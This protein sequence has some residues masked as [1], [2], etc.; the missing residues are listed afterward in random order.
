MNA[1]A[2]EVEYHCITH[3]FICISLLAQKY[4]ILCNHYAYKTI[5]QGSL[6]KINFI[7]HSSNRGQIITR[8]YANGQYELCTIQYTLQNM[9]NGIFAKYILPSS[10]NIR[11]NIKDIIIVAM[12]TMLHVCSNNINNILSNQI[13]SLIRWIAIPLS[14]PSSQDKVAVC[15]GSMNHHYEGPEKCRNMRFGQ[16][17]IF[18]SNYELK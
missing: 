7:A 17:T 1:N 3:L 9:E 16:L 14:V 5:D 18:I 8:Q 15:Q 6:K 11:R 10:F 13:A 12:H 2:I 4:K